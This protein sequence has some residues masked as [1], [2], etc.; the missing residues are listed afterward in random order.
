[1]AHTLESV[2]SL[3]LLKGIINDQPQLNS[4]IKAIAFPLQNL[5][6]FFS[7]LKEYTSGINLASNHDWQN[8][9]YFSRYIGG[10]LKHR[11]CRGTPAL[12]HRYGGPGIQMTGALKL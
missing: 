1:M 10:K 6:F 2:S 8:S 5:F 4:S 11:H 9:G 12:K 3:Q 7:H